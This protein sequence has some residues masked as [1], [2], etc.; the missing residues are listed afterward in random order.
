[1]TAL[2]FTKQ[3]FLFGVGAVILTLSWAATFN[4]LQWTHAG[5]LNEAKAAVSYVANIYMCG[6]FYRM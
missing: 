1:M 5:D 6:C 4:S 2:R 3:D